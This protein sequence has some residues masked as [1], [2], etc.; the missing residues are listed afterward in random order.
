MTNN[1][2]V[3]APFGPRIA[4]LKIPKN[5]INKMNKEIDRIVDNQNLSKKFDYSKELVGQVSQELQLPKAFINKYL[6]N[7]LFKVTKSY[8]EKSVNKKIT[9]FKINNVWVVRQFENEYN[10]IHYHDGHISGVGYLKIPK[11]LNKDTRSHKHN[12]KTHGTIDFIHGSRSFLN[13]SI[14]N[15]QPK[16][17]DM[18]LFPNY[19]MHTAYPFQSSEERRSFSFNAEIDQKIANV[20]KH[21]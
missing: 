3:L 15:H 17:A 11:S 18:I 14:Y 10:P 13:K 21:E 5:L 16:V 8:I 6:K 7:F 20:F 12:L 1:V 2:N 19:L 9:K 4:R